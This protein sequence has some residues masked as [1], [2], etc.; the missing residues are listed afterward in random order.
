MT[1]IWR[2]NLPDVVDDAMLRAAGLTREA[3]RHAV[4]S[5]RLYVVH[6]GVYAVGRPRLSREGPWMAAVLA[7]GPAAMLSMTPAGLHWEVLERG[8]ERPHVSV[9]SQAGRTAPRGVVLHRAATLT[10]ADRA[11]R[12]GIPVTSLERTLIDLARTTDPRTIKAAVRQAER[13]HRLDLATLRARVAEPRTSIGHA[14]LFAL[15][16]AYVPA[17][18]LTDS[19]LETAFLGLCARH[20]LPRPDTTARIGPYRPDFLWP[21][22]R[23]VVETDGRETHDTDVAFLEDRIRDRAMRALGY[24]VLRFTWA[25]VMLRPGAVAAE[26]RAALHRRRRERAGAVANWGS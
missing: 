24:E 20:R 17:S 4:R 6:P 10:P 11:V 25:E 16:S 14:R 5:G 2:L 23:L 15:L 21:A 12:R 26:V 7:C 9:P 8:D 13:R 19:E 22:E 18:G 3:V 1:P